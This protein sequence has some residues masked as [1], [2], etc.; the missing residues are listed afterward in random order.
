MYGDNNRVAD[1]WI[2]G[3][4]IMQVKIILF[5]TSL[6]RFSR[7]FAFSDR[8]MLTSPSP[9]MVLG[10]DSDGWIHCQVRLPP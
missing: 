8:S 1:F 4:G 6:Y 2:R 9:L 10:S 3:P 7:S 5:D